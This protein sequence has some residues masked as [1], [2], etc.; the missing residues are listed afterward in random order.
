MERRFKCS[1]PTSSAESDSWSQREQR[2]DE[3]WCTTCFCPSK[4]PKHVN[5]DKTRASHCEHFR[6]VGWPNN[7]G[8]NSRSLWWLCLCT[9]MEGG[10]PHPGV[11]RLVWNVDFF[12]YLVQETK[13]HSDPHNLHVIN[14]P[15]NGKQHTIG[16]HVNAIFSPQVDKKVNDDFLKCM[17]EWSVWKAQ[18]NKS[19]WRELHQCW[20]MTI[21]F[22]HTWWHCDPWKRRNP[23]GSGTGN[24]FSWSSRPD[25]MA[26]CCDFVDEVEAIVRG[27]SGEGH[28]IRENMPWQQ[29]HNSIR[30]Q[31]QEQL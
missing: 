1:G 3:C 24:S 23:I 22:C 4:K 29:K 2:Q 11:E 6:S 18:R 21:D 26:A 27:S 31:W 28:I 19:L 8:D 16:F 9:R 17:T 15:V 7:W 20:G 12:N 30:E 14:N 5:E 13:V 25:N 10:T